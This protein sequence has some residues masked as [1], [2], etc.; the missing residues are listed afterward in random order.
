[1]KLNENWWCAVDWNDFNNEQRRK[2]VLWLEEHYGK[3]F[4]AEANFGNRFVKPPVRKGRLLSSLKDF[5]EDAIGFYPNDML[6]KMVLI[7]GCWN[8]ARFLTPYIEQVPMREPCYVGISG[9]IY[10]TEKELKEGDAA[11]RRLF[12]DLC[13]VIGEKG[14]KKVRD[15]RNTEFE[16]RIVQP[17]SFVDKTE[18]YDNLAIAQAR[19][20]HLAQTYFRLATGGESMEKYHDFSGCDW[21]KQEVVKYPKSVHS[22]K[23]AQEFNETSYF[24]RLRSSDQDDEFLKFAEEEL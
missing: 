20:M 10:H 5:S 12:P 1:M 3:N 18:I 14:F 21:M 19:A 6:Q 16:Y 7:L 11:F 17:H 2:T 8:P 22:E 24:D 4:A 9:K 15:T 13:R 23:L